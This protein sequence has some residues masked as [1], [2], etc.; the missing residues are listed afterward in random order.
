MML[1]PPQV[2]L[3]LDCV[4]CSGEGLLPWHIVERQWQGLEYTLRK[5]AGLIGPDRPKAWGCQLCDAG[6]TLEYCE[7]SY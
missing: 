6:E 3:R 7:D 2:R 4:L 5:S 1:A